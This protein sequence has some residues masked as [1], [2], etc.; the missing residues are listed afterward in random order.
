MK[1]SV[2]NMLRPFDSSNIPLFSR[3]FQVLLHDTG[4]FK[5]NIHN[6]LQECIDN[7]IPVANELAIN[8][9]KFILHSAG[10]LTHFIGFLLQL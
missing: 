3:N 1:G 4:H 9:I 7:L 2:L 6:G 5:L 8:L 10:H